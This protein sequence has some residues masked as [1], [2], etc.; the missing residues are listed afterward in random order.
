MAAPE[1]TGRARAGSRRWWLCHLDLIFL[2][3]GLAL[4]GWMLSR[5]PLSDIYGAVVRMGPVALA[6]PLIALAWFPTHAT[7]LWLL[8]DGAA[9]W[10]EVLYNRLVGDGYNALLPMAGLG[11]EPFKARHLSRYAPF[12]R[13]V[14]ALVRDRV[15]DNAIGFLFSAAGVLF[16]LPRF[17]L[18]AML[19]DALWVYAAIAATLGALSFW[20]VISR[21]PGRLGKLLGRWLTGSAEEPPTLPLGRALLAAAWSMA[22]RVLGVC[23]IAVLLWAIDAPVDLATALFVDSALNAAGFLGFAFPQGI[24]VFEGS[25]VYLLGCLGVPAPA[26]LAFALVRRGRMLVVSLLGVVLHL[27]R[28][29]RSPVESHMLNYPPGNLP[30][31][32]AH[33]LSYLRHALEPSWSVLDVG[34]GEGW[35]CAEL[36]L[37]GRQVAG[38]DIVD[39]RKTDLA[40]FQLWNGE[41]LPFPDESFDVVA[42]VFVLHHVPNALKPA[43]LREARRVARKRVF[44]LEDTPRTPL[45]WLAGWMHG[46]RHRRQIGSTADFG[47]Y[48]QREWERMCPEHGLAIG[49]STRV[50]RFERLWWRPWARSAF[51]LDKVAD[52]AHAADRAHATD[53]ASRITGPVC[54]IAARTVDPE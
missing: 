42:L 20:L 40:A 2:G 25:S 34:C 30:H 5:Q 9:P 14:A 16:T 18:P 28:R 46:H 33:T 37:E 31:V 21:L 15:I 48:T 26:A 50:P 49:R 27:A 39:V 52:H 23:E 11:G 22:S 35:V 1:S 29:T 12:D 17:A 13:V 7:A 4:L 38:V 45:D 24:G 51:V 8:L 43:L 32:T 41:Q 47:F 3:L 44:I 19:G 54:P 10:G 36:A 53:R 6:T